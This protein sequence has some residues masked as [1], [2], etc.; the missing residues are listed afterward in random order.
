MFRFLSLLLP[1]MLFLGAGCSKPAKNTVDG[2]TFEA[3]RD[4]YVVM[5]TKGCEDAAARARDLRG[6]VK[7]FTILPRP[8][9]LAALRHSWLKTR[10]AHLKVK[11][12][13]SSG[14]P[15]MIAALKNVSVYPIDPVFLDHVPG[16]PG[17]GLAAI[18]FANAVRGHL[19]KPTRSL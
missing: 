3:V 17:V 18:H 2:R 5:A 15:A 19:R 10:E 1:P 8:A 7:S 16:V 14:G 13:Q 4:H 9:T 11:T 12:F 6:E